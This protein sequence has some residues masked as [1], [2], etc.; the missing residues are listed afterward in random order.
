MGRALVF[1]KPIVETAFGLSSTRSSIPDDLFHQQSCTPSTP[2]SCSSLSSPGSL[3]HHFLWIRSKRLG[4][5]CESRSREQTRY[6]R[7]A[8]IIDPKSGPVWRRARPALICPPYA[9]Q[10]QSWEAKGVGVDTLG[11]DESRGLAHTHAS[12]VVQRRGI[13]RQKAR[14]GITGC[15]RY[16]FL[17]HSKYPFPTG[18]FT[19]YRAALHFTRRCSQPP[20]SIGTTLQY[21][22]K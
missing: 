12:T 19:T 20:G 2:A 9:S 16:C 17:V 11:I 18:L 5:S 21:H 8:Q 22:P 6:S 13:V 4:C 14:Q 1:L 3:Q 10:R 7:E 15:D